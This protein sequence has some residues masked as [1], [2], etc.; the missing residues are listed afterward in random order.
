MNDQ[1]FEEK[2]L[3]KK[4][5]PRGLHY[6]IPIKE[7]I[8][9]AALFEF[10]SNGQSIWAI[11]ALDYSLENKHWFTFKLAPSDIEWINKDFEIIT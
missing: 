4:V 5:K 7:Y 9:T 2:W 8:V 3:N 11:K 10:E 1:E 6:Q